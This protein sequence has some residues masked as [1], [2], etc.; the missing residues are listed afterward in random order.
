[1]TSATPPHNSSALAVEIASVLKIK[2]QQV[3]KYLQVKVGDNITKETIL[4]KKDALMGMNKI[5]AKSPV[6]GVVS[7]IDEEK[8]VIVVQTGQEKQNE[9]VEKNEVTRQSINPKNQKEIEVILGFGSGQGEGLMVKSALDESVITSN[10]EGKIL[11]MHEPP[12]LSQMYKASAVDVAGVVVAG[13]NSD[14]SQKLVDE[15]ANKIHMGFLLL[16]ADLALNLLHKKNLEI[17]GQ[18]K[19]LII[20]D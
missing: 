8:G 14:Q 17:K 16:P 18:D 20:A 9:M 1:M 7:Q 2:P 3:N 15:L 11:L 10:L 5:Q 4:A 12:T 6:V 19:I 13:T